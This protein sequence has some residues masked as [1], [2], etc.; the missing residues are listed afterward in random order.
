MLSDSAK[1]TIAKIDSMPVE[2]VVE[3]VR[4]CTKYALEMRNITDEHITWMEPCHYCGSYRRIKYIDKKGGIIRC[5]LECAECG[6]DETG[7]FDA[8]YD[9]TSNPGKLYSIKIGCCP[10]CGADAE[11]QSRIESEQ[12]VSFWVECSECGLRT[13]GG[14]IAELEVQRW[15]QR[16]NEMEDCAMNAKQAKKMRHNEKLAYIAAFEK[17]LAQ[18]PPKWKIWAWKRWKSERPHE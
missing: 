11:L 13:D 14:Y 3:I 17:W 15:N 18:E 4:K 12:K 5:R 16:V 2:E 1:E 10:C 6:R 9:V 8:W 7:S